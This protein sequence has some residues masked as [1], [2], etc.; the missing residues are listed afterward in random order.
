MFYKGG[1]CNGHITKQIIKFNTA[2]LSM[3]VIMV[4]SLTAD[5]RPLLP[6]L[7]PSGQQR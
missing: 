7:L 2:I 3:R 6:E 1:F 5:L 4:G